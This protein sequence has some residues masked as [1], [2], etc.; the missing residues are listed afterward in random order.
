VRWFVEGRIEFTAG[1]VVQVR[2]TGV[3]GDTM[4]SPRNIE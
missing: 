2:G 4:V 1:D 3:P